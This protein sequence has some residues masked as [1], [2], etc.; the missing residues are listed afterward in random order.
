MTRPP[1]S[2][3][4]AIGAGSLVL[5]TAVVAASITADHDA[6]EV[7]KGTVERFHGSTASGMIVKTW[8]P[9]RLRNQAPVNAVSRMRERVDRSDATQARATPAP[10]VTA[11]G[12]IRIFMGHLLVDRL[13]PRH[14]IATSRP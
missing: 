6:T 11:P 14:S 10:R 13:V 5:R 4:A 12:R 7:A 8:S 9:G 1:P 3:T 2:T